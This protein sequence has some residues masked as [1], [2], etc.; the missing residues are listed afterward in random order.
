M[1]NRSSPK[2]KEYPKKKCLA[3]FF[4]SNFSP[5]MCMSDKHKKAFAIKKQTAT[6]GT[7]EN[8]SPGVKENS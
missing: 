4:V 2:G 3:N 6:D 7:K 1:R 8:R 5:R